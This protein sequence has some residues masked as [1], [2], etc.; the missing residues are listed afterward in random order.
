MAT[1]HIHKSHL[2]GFAIQ[3]KKR[4]TELAFGDYGGNILRIR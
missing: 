4:E 2:G 3:K 1:R